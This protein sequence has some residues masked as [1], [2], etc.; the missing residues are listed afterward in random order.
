MDLF[1]PEPERLTDHAVSF[2]A[3]FWPD[4]LELAHARTSRRPHSAL[5]R[6]TGA[7]L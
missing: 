3:R 6:R 4:C 5:R 7:C 1:F 2:A